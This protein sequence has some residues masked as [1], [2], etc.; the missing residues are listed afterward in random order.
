M[1]EW[2]PNI[3]PFPEQSSSHSD[4]QRHMHQHAHATQLAVSDHR[5]GTAPQRTSVSDS[6]FTPKTRPWKDV[7][8]DRFK[9]GTNWKYG[10]CK[11]QVF[12]GHR[13]GVMCLQFNDQ[14]LAT[15]S[16][17][18]EIKIWD[19]HSAEELRTLKS[20]TSAVRCL[21]FDET[22]L[23]SGSLDG[24]IKIWN[25]RTGE[26]LS[27]LSGNSGGIIGL[28]FDSSILASG[29]CD[30][31]VRIWNFD[32]KSASVLRG[33]TDW[34]NSV[35]I[36]SASR[37]VFSA[38]DDT[39]V[40]LWDLDSMTCIKTFEGHV[41]HVQQLVLL[42][43]DYELEDAEP[44]D[45]DGTSS[46][47]STQTPP[48]E[49]A[50]HVI[51]EPFGA[52]FNDTD[53]QRPPRYIL[54]GALDTTIRLWDTYTG[55]SIRTYF[56]HIEGVWALAA[57]TLRVVSGSQDRTVKIWDTKGKCERT[58]GGH[59]GP[60]TCIGLSDSRMCSGGE[61]CEVRMYSF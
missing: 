26:L 61:D 28:H 17:D 31:T 30:G 46:S 45:H 16:Y 56:G 41:G 39:T 40:K 29:S 21:Q 13:N 25:W 37:T 3:T 8:K 47:I 44:D 52:S 51:A 59:A 34:V 35:K 58:F 2:S 15:G 14:I 6:Y 27:T 48:P 33:H 9:V 49:C 42:P 53:R 38:S 24:T 43:C 19:I 10:R 54:T 4:G 50:D 32:N 18:T 20:H 23:I 1:N 5:N 12:Q 36:D 60:V 11:V 7:Y 57:D 55:K 22:K